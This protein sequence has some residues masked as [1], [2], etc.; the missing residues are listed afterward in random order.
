VLDGGPRRNSRPGER[1][2]LW[3]AGIFRLL[4]PARYR[5]V[6]T[7]AVART[8][9]TATFAQAPGVHLIEPERIG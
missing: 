1:V 6:G 3:F 5:A 2:G 4:L 8:L 7:D 9:L